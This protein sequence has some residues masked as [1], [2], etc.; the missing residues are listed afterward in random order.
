MI[1]LK[2][3]LIFNIEI[4]ILFFFKEKTVLLEE[5]NDS[6]L[7]WTA[8]LYKRRSENFHLQDMIAFMCTLFFL[9]I[10]KI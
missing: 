3:S 9:Q 1:H 8:S 2:E 7:T 6:M 10:W 4:K 5:E